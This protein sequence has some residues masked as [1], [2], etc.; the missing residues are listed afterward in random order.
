MQS[1]I[2]VALQI[3]DALPRDVIDIARVEIIHES[4]LK[5]ARHV[6]FVARPRDPNRNGGGCR[7]SG[8][9]DERRVRPF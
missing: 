8:V 4:E 1:T 7:W 3:T 5:L 9:K 2:S 6:V